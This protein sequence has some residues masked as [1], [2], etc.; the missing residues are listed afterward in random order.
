MRAP[1]EVALLLTARG[2]GYGNRQM[3]SEFFVPKVPEQ[4]QDDSHSSRI[5]EIRETNTWFLDGVYFYGDRACQLGRRILGSLQR[6]RLQV[7]E[8]KVPAVLARQIL[9]FL[10]A[11]GS[12]LGAALA[13]RAVRRHKRIAWNHFRQQVQSSLAPGAQLPRAS[14]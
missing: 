13:Y 9:A 10:I 8:G 11:F 14:L 5:E 2:R 6:L 3:E 4:P 1:G 7:G 12:V